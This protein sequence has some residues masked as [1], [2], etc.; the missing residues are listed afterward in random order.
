[1][2]INFG[3]LRDFACASGYSHSYYRQTFEARSLSVLGRTIQRQGSPSLRCTAEFLSAA[4]R[5]A[6]EAK[7]SIIRIDQNGQ[8][9]SGF[10]YVDLVEFQIDSSSL[11]AIAI[12]YQIGCHWLVLGGEFDFY[13]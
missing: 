12:G 7:R 9:L 10:K 5:H 13:E 6:A 1:M 11:T 8:V 3:T 2:K 4:K